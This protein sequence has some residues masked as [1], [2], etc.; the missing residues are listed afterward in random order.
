MYAAVLSAG[1]ITPDGRRVPLAGVRSNASLA[2]TP[3][4]DRQPEPAPPC[5]MNGLHVEVV[6][7]C[8]ARD[9]IE[10]MAS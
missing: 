6:D 2:T 3:M 9:R 7:S 10:A 8:T 1:E 5:P 4:A